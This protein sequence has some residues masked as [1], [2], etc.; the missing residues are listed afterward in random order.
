M[1]KTTIIAFLAAALAVP[2]LRADPVIPGA[3]FTNFALANSVSAT[4]NASVGN[5]FL[6]RNAT[7]IKFA[8]Q[9][10]TSKRS[11]LITAFK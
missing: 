7:W 1:S 6:S 3:G 8:M 2:G 11:G 4:V 5:A 9:T 10:F